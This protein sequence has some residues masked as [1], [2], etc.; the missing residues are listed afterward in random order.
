MSTRTMLRKP[1]NSRFRPSINY[2]YPCT[3]TDWKRRDVREE[4]QEEMMSGKVE[5]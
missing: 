3:A 1:G 2:I 5:K 4:G